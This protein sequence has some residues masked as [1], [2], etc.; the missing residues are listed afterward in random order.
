MMLNILVQKEEIL[1]GLTYTVKNK[2]Q[3]LQLMYIHIFLQYLLSI[4]LWWCFKSMEIQLWSDNE[5]SFRCYLVF[6]FSCWSKDI[7]YIDS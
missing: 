1:S 7:F 4:Q 6:L 3:I 2:Q 5:F